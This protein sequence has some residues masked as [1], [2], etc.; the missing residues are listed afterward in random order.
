MAKIGG[1]AGKILY[2]DLTRRTSETKPLSQDLMS[3]FIGGPG[4]NAKLAY[5][6][7]KP[8]TE[9]SSPENAMLINIPPLVGTFAPGA[10]RASFMA[11]SPQT[12]TLAYSGTGGLYNLK[13]A[14]Y[15]ELVITGKA[16]KPVYLKIL[17]DEVEILDASDLW[18]KD[19]METTD[20]LWDKYGDEWNVACIGPAG[21][22]LVRYASINSN[23]FSLFAREGFGAVMGS[24]NLK[25]IVAWG[26]KDIE[27][28][29]RSRFREL[30]DT[31][32]K[33]IMGD[34]YFPAW[35]ALGSL[36]GLGHFERSGLLP[37]KNQQEGCYEGVHGNFFKNAEFI[38]RL[39]NGDVSCMACP[40][41]C[42]HAIKIKGGDYDGKV[43][44]LS[45]ILSTIQT[46][47]VTYTIKNYEET[48]MCADLCDRYGMD[49]FSIV[50]TI[51]YATEL[52]DKGIISQKDTDGMLLEWGSADLIKS[53]IPK[54]AL[55]QGFGDLLAEGC[56][57]MGQRIGGDAP[58]YA[59]HVKGVDT[60]YDPR[61]TIFSPEMF[62]LYTNT[63]GAYPTLQ[64]FSLGTVMSPETL[65]PL[66]RMIGV[67]EDRQEVI[68]NTP[69][70]GNEGGYNVPRLTKY[71]DEF[72]GL[73]DST[74]I[75]AR[76]IYN[77]FGADRIAEIYSALT[78]IKKN[79]REIL[80]DME[81]RWNV[82]KAFKVR[83]GL[84]KKE[85]DMGPKRWMTETVKWKGEEFSPI[86]QERID[87]LLTEYYDERGWDSASGLPTKRRLEELQLGDIA[88]D[89]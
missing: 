14:G 19:A 57:R 80:R 59:V 29:D 23:K 13:F 45:C 79:A 65:K 89:L 16:D 36:L 78:G 63:K 37:V 70:G 85:E 66:M 71:Y 76:S 34:R 35:R 43:A 8:K 42:K 51:A 86:P 54:I 46:F 38:G 9:F 32:R 3:N 83:G 5:E 31:A 39:K 81:R 18:G 82:E 52:Y 84:G 73:L 60:I 50:N 1:Y 67:P 49:Y 17:D 26:T 7:I 48:I 6:V 75:C 62:A 10:G 53:L 27:I 64:T 40:V 28:A 2:V 20:I 12:G 44:S 77:V 69:T 55:R 88:K 56:Y 47:G 58:K 4:I 74:G 15:D 68:L 87:A 25:A 11:V 21:E 41:G 72:Y 24:K 30:C 22:N 61:T 33:D